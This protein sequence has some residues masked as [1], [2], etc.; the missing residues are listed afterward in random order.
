M[1]SGKFEEISGKILREKI[2]SLGI[3]QKEL[4]QKVGVTKYAINRWANSAKIRISRESA[5]LLRETLKIESLSESPASVPTLNDFEAEWI[6][7]YRKMSPLNRAK[8][9]I[10]IEPFVS[11]K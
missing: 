5:K 2:A 10:A 7:I 6:G 9:R 11:G 4:A 3:S 1:E 8:A